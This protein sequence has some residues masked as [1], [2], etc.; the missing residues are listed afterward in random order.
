MRM[1]HVGIGVKEAQD[2]TAPLSS[3]QGYWQPGA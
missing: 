1:L 2:M 3:L